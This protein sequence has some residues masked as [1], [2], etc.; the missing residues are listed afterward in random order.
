MGFTAG[1][2]PELRDKLAGVVAAPPGVF[3]QAQQDVGTSS[4]QARSRW[5]WGQMK[6]PHFWFPCSSLWYFL[7]GLVFQH[8]NTAVQGMLCKGS[9]AP[10]LRPTT[11]TPPSKPGIH[12]VWLLGIQAVVSSC[13]GFAVHLFNTGTHPTHLCCGKREQ[14]IGFTTCNTGTCS[15][16]SSLI[17]GN[18]SLY[19]SKCHPDLW[20]T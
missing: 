19:S 20:R 18:N 6:S 4:T 7:A 17:C 11:E 14:S 13:L 2:G 12:F 9:E 5:P 3:P 15:Q 1:S 10:C 16:S 8:W